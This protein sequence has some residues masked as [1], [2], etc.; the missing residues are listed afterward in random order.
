[1]QHTAQLLC[2]PRASTV[3]FLKSIPRMRSHE[4]KRHSVTIILPMPPR[5]S[6]NNHNK[7]GSEGMKAKLTGRSDL[8]TDARGTNNSKLCQL[9]GLLVG[10]FMA[11]INAQP[12]EGQSH[13]ERKTM[14]V[15]LFVNEARHQVREYGTMPCEMN[16]DCRTKARQ[17]A[18]SFALMT[19]VNW[20]FVVKQR[21]R[22]LWQTINRSLQTPTKQSAMAAR[23]QCRWHTMTWSNVHVDSRRKPEKECLKMRRSVIERLGDLP[24]EG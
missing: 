24:A 20:P 17:G 13:K 18:P 3:F 7:V 21:L 9:R 2:M 23:E 22:G 11:I 8:T 15:A 6:T 16:N 14:A 5:S 19:F 10:D 1:M 4:V 12:Q